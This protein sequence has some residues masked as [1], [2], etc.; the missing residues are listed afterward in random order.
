M[1]FTKPCPTNAEVSAAVQTLNDFSLRVYQILYFNKPPLA[2]PGN[3]GLYKVD[4]KINAGHITTRLQITRTAFPDYS[5]SIRAD[6]LYIILTNIEL[7]EEA[8]ANGKAKI[9]YLACCP[10]AEF[11]PC[12]CVASFRCPVHGSQCHGSHD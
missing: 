3:N 4:V 10:L 8:I 1:K 9:H 2:Q 5:F 6:Q 12:V 11:S 7:I